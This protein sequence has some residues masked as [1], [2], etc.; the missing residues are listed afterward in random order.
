MGALGGSLIFGC[1]GAVAFSAG[2][3]KGGWDERVNNMPWRESVCK[4]QFAAEAVKKNLD[5]K[6]GV[7]LSSSTKA[8]TCTA[9]FSTGVQMT[10]QAVQPKP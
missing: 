1:L 9:N 10:W 3:A 4:S 2:L 6:Q 8:G 7:T 5:P